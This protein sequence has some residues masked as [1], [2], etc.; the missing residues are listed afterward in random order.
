MLWLSSGKPVTAVAVG[1]LWEAGE[2]ELDDPVQRFVP[3]FGTNGK[4]EIT[5][6]HLLT[7]TAGVRAIDL[8]WPR[9]SWDEVL[10]RLCDKKVEPRWIPG[11][12]A[13]YH[14]MSS[15]FVLGEILRRITGQSISTH[16][17]QEI[18]EPLGMT[19]CWVGAPSTSSG[20][21]GI[22]VAPI[23][24]TSEP[25]PTEHPWTRGRYL[26][27]PSPGANAVG[28]VRQLCRFYRMLL[29]RGTLD[30]VTL[31]N[32]QTVEA[33]TIRQRVGLFDSTFR[34][35]LDWGLG[36]VLDSRHYGDEASVYG[37]GTHCSTRVFGHSGYRSSIG[38]ADPEYDLAVA[39]AVNGTPDEQA[40][41]QRFH[42]TICA[43]Y[44]DLEL[45]SASAR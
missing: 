16:L 36:F 15:W 30:D 34:R 45:G 4:E 32:P 41:Q 40:H 27:Q 12:R 39:L 33:M 26:T 8:G 25:Q 24:D 1:R 5:I 43:V 28:P 19:D 9:S 29:G 31:L 11:R 7:H 35:P 6:R 18:F 17:R 2:L 3:E 20:D 38:F 22:D 44:E 13:G 37:Y 42:R 14:R 23:F 21:A 10:A